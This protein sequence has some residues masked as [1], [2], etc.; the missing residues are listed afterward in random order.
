MAGRV[1]METIL[2]LPASEGY[3]KGSFPK[4]N[5]AGM[6]VGMAPLMPSAPGQR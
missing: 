4:K 1:N 6:A 3:G 5:G 2:L